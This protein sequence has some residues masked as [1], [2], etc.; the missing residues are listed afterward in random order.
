MNK[1]EHINNEPAKDPDDDDMSLV[2]YIDRA[3]ELICEMARAKTKVGQSERA[4]AALAC[5]YSARWLIDGTMPE[6]TSVRRFLPPAENTSAP[7]DKNSG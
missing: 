5:L 2:Q 1:V 4:A 7:F 6:N 3:A